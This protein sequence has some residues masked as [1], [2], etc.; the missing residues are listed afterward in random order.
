M[1]LLR[2]LF[3]GL[4][5][6]TAL[7]DLNADRLSTGINLLLD[8][9]T[10]SPPSAGSDGPAPLKYRFT[11]ISNKRVALAGEV[12]TPDNNPTRPYFQPAELASTLSRL[13]AGS[14]ASNVAANSAQSRVIYS[15]SAK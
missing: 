2:S 8:V 13:I 4:P 12:P 7:P 15:V 9:K 5:V 6:G 11:S 3:L 1:S 14:E 10:V